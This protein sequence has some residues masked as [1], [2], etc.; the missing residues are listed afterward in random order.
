MFTCNDSHRVKHQ[1]R[2]C[3]NEESCE[4]QHPTKGKVLM[5]NLHADVAKGK[6]EKREG[7]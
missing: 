1:C 5:A 2:K 6:K 3:W 4:V 7:K